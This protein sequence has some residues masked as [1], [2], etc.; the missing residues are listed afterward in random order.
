MTDVEKLVKDL[1]ELH[2]KLKNV[3][4]KYKEVFEKLF[5]SEKKIENYHILDILNQETGKELKNLCI[6]IKTLNYFKDCLESNQEISQE[7]IAFFEDAVDNLGE[8]V[9]ETVD[10]INV[11]YRIF[12]Q[13][14]KIL[15]ELANAIN[16]YLKLLKGTLKEQEDIYKYI[17]GLVKKVEESLS[18]KSEQYK[19]L[20]DNIKKLKERFGFSQQ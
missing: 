18:K 7:A 6:I 19:K 12:V 8:N 10:K 15:E 4:V 1:D 14:E 9:K 17:N 5:G 20:D 13:E 16:E 3:E 2:S 11:I